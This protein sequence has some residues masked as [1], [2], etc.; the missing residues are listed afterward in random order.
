MMDAGSARGYG[1]ALKAL[2][3]SLDGD[4]VKGI[5]I[6]VA[7]ASVGCYFSFDNSINRC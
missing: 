4:L 5:G 3:L 7:S 1:H 2:K 6:R